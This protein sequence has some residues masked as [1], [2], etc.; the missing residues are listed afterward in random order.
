MLV[1]QKLLKIAESCE[2][3]VY[4]SLDIVKGLDWSE[5]VKRAG[6][7]DSVGPRVISVN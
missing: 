4:L 3:E 2:G 7:Q 1:T 6:R 5:I